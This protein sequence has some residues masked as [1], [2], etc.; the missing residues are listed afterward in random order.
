MNA[1]DLTQSTGRA[2]TRSDALARRLL[3]IPENAERLSLAKAQRT[4]SA[5]MVLSGLRCLLSY[6]VLP[7]LLPLIGVAT[8]VEPAVG[9]PIATL[10]LVFDVRGI[11]RLWLADSRHRWELTASM[12]P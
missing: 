9:V 4:F 10:A 11:R 2:R 1:V 12:S 5:A 6:I 8:G 3:C 7:V